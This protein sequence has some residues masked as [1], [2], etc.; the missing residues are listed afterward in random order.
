[1]DPIFASFHPNLLLFSIGLLRIS[2]IGHVL[3]FAWTRF[4]VIVQVKVTSSE[5]SL[6]LE[7]ILEP[8]SSHSEQASTWQLHVVILHIPPPP[9]P[10]FVL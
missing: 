6:T 9:R 10:K 3:P 4:I 2:A 1:M 8:S 5:T 7:S